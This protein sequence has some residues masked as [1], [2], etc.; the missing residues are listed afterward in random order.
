MKKLM[1]LMCIA[2][3]IVA[4]AGCEDDN[5]GGGNGKR[6]VEQDRLDN[7]L[8]DTGS[9]DKA[10]HTEAMGHMRLIAR[11]VKFTVAKGANPKTLYPSISGT[12]NASKLAKIGMTPSQLTGS[13]Y[14]PS[15]Y[16]IVIIGKQM[17]ISA[18]Q[19]KSRGRVEPQKFP[20]P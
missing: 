17:T 9:V 16:S 6:Y 4:T 8:V 10:V 11:Q 5:T 15:D 14:K 19:I 12:L 13:F 2:A 3:C 20:V 18:A 1:L 7:P